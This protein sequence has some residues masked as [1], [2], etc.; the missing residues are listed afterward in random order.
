MS[1]QVP[2][3]GTVLTE[4]FAGSPATK[5]SPTIDRTP[6]PGGVAARLEKVLGVTGIEMNEG[7]VPVIDQLYSK[8]PRGLVAP[9]RPLS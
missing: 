5:I 6:P 3:S 8:K 1:A 9:R 7:F 2:G 4:I